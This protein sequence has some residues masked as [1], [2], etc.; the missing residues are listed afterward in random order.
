MS[1]IFGFAA[2]IVGLA[3]IFGAVFISHHDMDYPILVYIGYFICLIGI[4]VISVWVMEF[5]RKLFKLK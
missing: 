1:I 4:S 5:V 2:I 3:I